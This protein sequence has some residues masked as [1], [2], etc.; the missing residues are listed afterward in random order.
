VFSRRKRRL[1]V[2]VAELEKEER[3]QLSGFLH[4]TLKV[5]VSLSGSKVFV[6]SEGL[7]LEELRKLVNKFVY[8]RNL[9]RKYWVAVEGG[10]VRISRFEKAK[11]REKRRGEGTPPQTITHGW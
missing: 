4:L 11:K 2:Y 7:S 6:G 8:H 3:D 5:D 9:N 1:E 10:G